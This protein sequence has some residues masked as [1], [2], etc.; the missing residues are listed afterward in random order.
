[1][2]RKAGWFQNNVGGCHLRTCCDNDNANEIVTGDDNHNDN[3]DL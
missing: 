1:M 2:P 3:P